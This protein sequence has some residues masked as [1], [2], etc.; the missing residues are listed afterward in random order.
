VPAKRGSVEVSVYA[1]I[2]RRAFPTRLFVCLLAV[3]GSLSLHFFILVALVWAGG[4]HRYKPAPPRL[5][6]SLGDEASDGSAMQWIALYE[7][8]SP[9]ADESQRGAAGQMPEP[10]LIRSH[11]FD[12]GDVPVEPLG[13]ASGQVGPKSSESAA[14]QGVNA[15]LFGLY[16]R[17]IDARIERAWRRPRTPIGAPLFACRARITQDLSG[18]VLDLALQECNADARWRESLKSA[19]RSS[20]PLPAPPDPAV[21]RRTVYLTFRS[22]AFGADSSPD[23]YESPQSAARTDLAAAPDTQQ[24]LR[25]FAHALRKP[26][27]P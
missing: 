27:S 21:Y 3:L 26:V 2:E 16:V 11:S 20:S 14:D 9:D 17:Q 22:A 8:Q 23:S 15:K 6:D 1:P 18:N 25:K 5:T 13:D 24:R 19:I 7:A 10:R 4:S 12:A